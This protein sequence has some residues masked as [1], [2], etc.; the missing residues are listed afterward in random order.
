MFVRILKITL[1]QSMD[2]VRKKCVLFTCFT[3]GLRC[4]NSLIVIF[5]YHLK[6]Q[7]ALYSFSYFHL[8]HTQTSLFIFLLS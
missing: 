2:Y 4:I 6:L 8:L 5:V 3:L 1:D 7:S